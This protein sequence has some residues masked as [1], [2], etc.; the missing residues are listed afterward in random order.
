MN[1]ILYAIIFC[2]FVNDTKTNLKQLPSLE[3]LFTLYYIFIYSS[4]AER[5]LRVLH[6]LIPM[7]SSSLFLQS[8][9]E[10]SLY[11]F[12]D[13]KV[14]VLSL[15]KLGLYLTISRTPPFLTLSVHLTRLTYPF[16]LIFL[17]RRTFLTNLLLS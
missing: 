2:S 7:C 4:Y 13:M 6:Y 5:L 16:S 8:P 14:I 9:F 1:Q 12:H 15:H 10:L 11:L 17:K 3:E